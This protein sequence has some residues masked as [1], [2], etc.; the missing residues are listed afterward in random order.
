MMRHYSFAATG[1]DF[2]PVIFSCQLRAHRPWGPQRERSRES[3]NGGRSG[4]ARWQYHRVSL[5]GLLLSFGFLPVARRQ[6]GPISF[7]LLLVAA[8]RSAELD[9]GV[10][11]VC[12]G[13][14][15]QG[16]GSC[17]RQNTFYPSTPPPPCWKQP[18]TGVRSI[19]PTLTR[20]KDGAGR[21]P[22]CL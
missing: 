20:E 3:G 5:K 7:A 9:T 2:Q 11:C 1:S 8:V 19:S 13:C 18:R 14:H 12:D 4:F 21:G 6:S 17:A 15:F 16:G 22:P 10:P